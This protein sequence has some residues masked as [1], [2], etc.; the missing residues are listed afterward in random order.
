MLLHSGMIS[1]VAVI[2][3]VAVA[4][5]ELDISKKFCGEYLFENVISK[6]QVYTSFILRVYR[7]RKKEKGNSRVAK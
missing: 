1:F 7:F 4:S 3:S 2:S 6:C 5:S